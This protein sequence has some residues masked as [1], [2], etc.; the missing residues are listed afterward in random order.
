MR[1]LRLEVGGIA[2]KSEVLE[3]LAAQRKEITQEIDQKLEKISEL[4]VQS[5]TPQVI[6][7]PLSSDA[8]V[9]CPPQLSGTTSTTTTTTSSSSVD[10]DL[11]RGGTGPSERDIKVLRELGID[12]NTVEEI[13]IVVDD[14][15]IERDSSNVPEAV[16]AVEQPPAEVS[17]ATGVEDVPTDLPVPEWD[18]PDDADASVRRR[19]AE[20]DAALG[21]ILSPSQASTVAEIRA[22]MG[23]S[24]LPLDAIRIVVDDD[25]APMENAKI[26]DETF[27]FPGPLGFHTAPGYPLV[28]ETVQPGTSAAIKGLESGDVILEVNGQAISDDNP[29]TRQMMA[30][31]PLRLRIKYHGRGSASRRGHTKAVSMATTS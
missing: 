30:I 28:I 16:G 31:R 27:V 8:P 15:V 17:A 22:S 24:P 14:D 20:A 5:F 13:R 4:A 7:R 29:V 19:K 11:G 23:L 12:V 1:D 2:T 25:D 3:A 9:F 6:S 10:V 21:A 26:V 18:D